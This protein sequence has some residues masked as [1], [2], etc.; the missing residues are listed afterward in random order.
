MFLKLAPLQAKYRFWAM[1]W[2]HYLNYYLKL[3][4]LQFHQLR[5]VRSIQ[6]LNWRTSDTLSDAS[7]AN[8]K[9]FGQE[10]PFSRLKTLWGCSFSSWASNFKLHSRMGK[11]AGRRAGYGRNIKGGFWKF[12]QSLNQFRN[13]LDV[14]LFILY[15][16]ISRRAALVQN[17]A[18]RPY[19]KCTCFKAWTIEHMPIAREMEQIKYESSMPLLYCR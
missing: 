8:A 15:N 7:T 1:S 11:G 14:H 5:S 16:L 13:F 9:Y 6:L 2:I 4:K 10:L 19:K 17:A 12:I 18:Y 3:P